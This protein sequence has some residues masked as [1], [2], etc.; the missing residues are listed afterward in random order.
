MEKKVSLDDFHTLS[1]IGQG[2]YAKVVL[3]RKK[4]NAKIYALKI[5][6]KRKLEERRHQKEHAFIEK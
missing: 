4:L 5:L 1:F 6:K 3:V 2:N